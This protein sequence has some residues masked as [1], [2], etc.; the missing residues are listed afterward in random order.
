MVR[1]A[2]DL[3]LGFEHE[4]EARSFLAEMR[5]RL[6]MF[7]LK[8]HPEKTRLIQFGRWVIFPHDSGHGVKLLA[9]TVSVFCAR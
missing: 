6:Q 8:L 4:G 5:E 1:Y 2:D 3:V 9:Q 7:G